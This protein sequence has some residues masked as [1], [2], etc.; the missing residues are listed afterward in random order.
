MEKGYPA[1]GDGSIEGTLPAEE[2][3]VGV[4][5]GAGV[6]RNLVSWDLVRFGQV[7]QFALANV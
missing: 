2:T 5:V 4:D 6:D 1:L 3:A 7:R